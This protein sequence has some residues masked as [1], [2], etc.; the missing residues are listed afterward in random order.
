MTTE[1]APTTDPTNP[2]DDSDV[3]LEVYAAHPKLVPTG[4]VHSRLERLI[5]A[6]ASGLR[7]EP[8]VRAAGGSRHTVGA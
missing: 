5:A 8:P 1:T 3:V 7:A 2:G 4:S 6:L